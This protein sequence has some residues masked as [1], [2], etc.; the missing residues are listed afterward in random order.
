MPIRIHSLGSEVPLEDM[1]EAQDSSQREQLRSDYPSELATRESISSIARETPF[2]TDLEPFKPKV[3]SIESFVAEKFAIKTDSVRII[4]LEGADLWVGDEN[5]GESYVE[6]PLGKETNRV[7]YKD[8]IE[9]KALDK[10]ELVKGESDPYN[11]YAVIEKSNKKVLWEKMEEAAKS[12]EAQDLLGEFN[13]R[14]LTPYQAA[15]LVSL[16]VR[17]SMEYDLKSVEEYRNRL[18][19]E[20]RR[21]INDMRRENYADYEAWLKKRNSRLD[22]LTAD[23][24]LEEGKGVC[25]HVSAAGAALYET[26]KE[27]QETPLLNGTYFG[28]YK[29]GLKGSHSREAIENHAYNLLVVAKPETPRQSASMDIT[30]VDLTAVM[31]DVPYYDTEEYDRTFQRV[32]S[33]VGFVQRLGSH[34]IENAE[35]EAKE[36]VEKFLKRREEVPINVKEFSDYVVMV[37][38]IK[39]D[40]PEEDVIRFITDKIPEDNAIRM[41]Y[42][43]IFYEADGTSLKKSDWHRVLASRYTSS[44]YRDFKDL[45]FSEYSRD[46]AA[47]L[48]HIRDDLE[49]SYFYG[50]VASLAIKATMQNPEFLDIQVSR[51]LQLAVKYKNESRGDGSLDLKLIDDL[52]SHLY[53]RLGNMD[54]VIWESQDLQK[55]IGILELVHHEEQDDDAFG[56]LI[57]KDLMSRVDEGQTLTAYVYLSDLEGT[58]IPTRDGHNALNYRYLGPVSRRCLKIDF[59]EDA[60]L[61]E[62]ALDYV[63][64][65]TLVLEGNEKFTVAMLEET[66]DLIHALNLLL[67]THVDRN[68]SPDE[69]THL[70]V[71]GLLKLVEENSLKVPL[72]SDLVY[73]YRKLI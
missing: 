34:F 67:K 32:S 3:R 44:V 16:V 48:Q 37:D 70:F 60:P 56:E 2:V 35:D 51:A 47:A 4:A 61:L 66:P 52:M 31:K 19:M 6:D 29:P 26:L 57:I 40:I 39:E 59:S 54:K 25:R 17:E 72:D 36:A 38:F 62:T 9:E 15:L 24:L 43:N 18:P 46:V 12:K 7:L 68:E 11:V 63:K 10:Q 23:Q 27:K 13:V 42:F 30:V 14:H 69:N 49:D 53:I 55:L 21:K 45:D 50:G 64:R 71:E 1:E 58:S 65:N 41:Q 22:S 20:E 28:Y 8:W 5:L 73:Q 33:A